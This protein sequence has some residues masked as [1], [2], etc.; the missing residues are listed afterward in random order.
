MKITVLCGH[1]DMIKRESY[2]SEFEKK[3][4]EIT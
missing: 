4:A 1:T 3:W 2:L